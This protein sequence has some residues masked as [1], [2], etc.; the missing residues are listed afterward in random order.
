MLPAAQ[1]LN[2]LACQLDSSYIAFLGFR[3]FLHFRSF[4]ICCSLSLK[5]PQ[6][7]GS[8]PTAAPLQKLWAL[9]QV[10]GQ[11]PLCVYSGPQGK[12]RRCWVRLCRNPR[13]NVRTSC[14][15]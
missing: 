8:A 10:P 5:L 7:S 2:L 14:Y 1:R 6:A 11:I 15:R 13:L 12:G 4:C 9:G 3:N